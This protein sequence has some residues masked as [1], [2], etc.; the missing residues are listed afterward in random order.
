MRKIILIN[1]SPRKNKNSDQIAEHIKAKINEL[2]KIKGYTENEIQIK[3]MDLKKMDF[4]GCI[5]C[6]YCKKHRG[7]SIK[8]DIQNMYPEF[9]DSDAT[10]VVTPIYFDGTPW[11]LKAL[12]DRLQA[13]YNSKYVLKDSLID[14]DKKRNGFVVSIAGG[15]QYDTQ[16][17]GNDLVM[18]FMFR[19]INTQ[20]AEHIKIAN[21]DEQ[22]AI[23]N[24]SS[25]EKIDGMLSTL[26]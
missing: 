7:C 14:R 11:K 17:I 10:I 19:S 4:I 12:I 3:Y 1:A 8:D 25:L 20:Y 5:D 23:K 9:N 21:T 16:F 24:I 26:I 6:G 18:K 13:I 15:P 22:M 2:A